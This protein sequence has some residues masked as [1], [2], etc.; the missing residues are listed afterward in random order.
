MEVKRKENIPFR[1]DLNLESMPFRDQNPNHKPI[2][3]PY[4]CLCVY[5]VP[6]LPGQCRLLY[7]SWNCKSF[8]RC[9]SKAYLMLTITHIQAMNLHIYL[10]YE[11]AIQ[12]VPYTWSLSW[13]TLYVEHLSSPHFCYAIIPSQRNWYNRL[14]HTYLSTRLLGG[15]VSADICIPYI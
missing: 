2:K 8:K 7:S 10:V 9:A 3:S 13:K 14:I 4:A 12:C 1:V 6:C 5:M 11:Q 15:Q